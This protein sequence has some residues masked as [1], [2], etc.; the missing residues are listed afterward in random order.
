MQQTKGA[1]QRAT[2]LLLTKVKTTPPPPP[3]PPHIY[4]ISELN[5]ISLSLKEMTSSPYYA[6]C[7]GAVARERE[8]R[9]KRGR[10]ER[11]E[12]SGG[13]GLVRVMATH[14][15]LTTAEATLD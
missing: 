12:N 10:E 14:H 2:F 4:L 11:R 1:G 3:A 15:C 8:D 5:L 13:G 9:S 7:L 6:S